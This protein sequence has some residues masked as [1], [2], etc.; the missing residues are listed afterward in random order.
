MLLEAAQLLVITVGAVTLWGI[1][2]YLW[3]NRHL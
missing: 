3:R 2:D 1:C